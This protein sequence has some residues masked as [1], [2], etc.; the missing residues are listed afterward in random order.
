[1]NAN[2]NNMPGS[3]RAGTESPALY[4]PGSPGISSMESIW[5]MGVA[6]KAT[7]IVSDLGQMPQGWHQE[8]DT[9]AFR[10]E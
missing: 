5:G 2:N 8:F 4:M 3:F 1:M 10:Q 7:P 9:T 6:Q